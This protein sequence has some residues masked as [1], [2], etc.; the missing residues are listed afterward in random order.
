LHTT[1]D[2]RVIKPA[3]SCVS[4]VTIQLR[5][6][7]EHGSAGQFEDIAILLL[8]AIL[9]DTGALKAK[10]KAIEE[11]DQAARLDQPGNRHW[12]CCRAPVLVH[13]SRSL[14]PVMHVPIYSL[15]PRR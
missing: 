2:P 12:I 11:N 15:A 8:S 3:S 5:S 10:G 1:A 14:G 7:L 13:N 4:L 9:I 6:T